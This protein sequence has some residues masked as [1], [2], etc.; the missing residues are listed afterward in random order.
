MPYFYRPL[1]LPPT[2]LIETRV[3]VNVPAGAF[4]PIDFRLALEEGFQAAVPRIR[5]EGNVEW[6]RGWPRRSGRLIRSAR[7]RIR[8]SA[9][10]LTIGIETQNVF[11]A[12]FQPAW[13]ANFARMLRWLERRGADIAQEEVEKAL[14]RL[15]KEAT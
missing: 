12:R 9:V 14:T 10:D 6:K 15:L 3:V 13:D 4:R 2:G 8:S 7:L 1:P 5:K 11:Y